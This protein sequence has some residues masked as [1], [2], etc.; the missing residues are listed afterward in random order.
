MAPLTVTASNILTNVLLPVL[1]S[2]ELWRSE[3]AR[4]ECSQ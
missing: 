2:V 3:L 1:L 4:E